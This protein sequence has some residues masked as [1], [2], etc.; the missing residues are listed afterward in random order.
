MEGAVTFEKRNNNTTLVTITTDNTEGQGYPAYIY[1]NAA[2]QGGEV[3]VTL[4]PVVD[5]V[6]ITNIRNFDDESNA[7]V[8][9]DDLLA[10]D[11]YVAIQRST[12]DATIVAQT[13]IGANELTGESVTYSLDSVDVPGI[14]GTATFAQRQSGETLVTLALT[15]TPADGTP[16]SPHSCQH[17]SRRGGVLW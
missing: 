16:P 10:Y 7:T 13:D 17:G 3:A 6:S 8:T 5:G 15:G 11:G 9:Y 12:E 4:N 1:Q 2:V 14:N